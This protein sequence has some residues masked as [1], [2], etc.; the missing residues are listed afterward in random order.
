M[1]V[2]FE[3]LRGFVQQLGCHRQVGLGAVQVVMPEMG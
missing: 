2:L 3:A 1:D